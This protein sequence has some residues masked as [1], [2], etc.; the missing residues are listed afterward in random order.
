[1]QGE[2][3]RICCAIALLAVSAVPAHAAELD[4][5]GRWRTFNDKTGKPESIVRIVEVDG[6]GLPVFG[7]MQTWARE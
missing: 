4:I 5:A 6:V 1:M 2:R 3:V 7:R